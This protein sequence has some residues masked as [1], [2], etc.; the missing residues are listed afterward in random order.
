MQAWLSYLWSTAPSSYSQI[1]STI[2]AGSV[3]TTGDGKQLAI[4]P[5]LFSDRELF[6]H[7]WASQILVQWFCLHQFIYGKNYQQKRIFLSE[8]TWRHLGQYKGREIFRCLAGEIPP[9]KTGRLRKAR[10]VTK[11]LVRFVK[12]GNG[13]SGKFVPKHPPYPFSSGVS[14]ECLMTACNFSSKFMSGQTFSGA[15]TPHCKASGDK[16]TR[17][18]V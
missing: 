18:R 1:R 16:A 7:P 8:W 4:F 11:M 6:P 2:S 13:K 17:E 12:R 10:P 14:S 3:I 5:C 15:S 9:K